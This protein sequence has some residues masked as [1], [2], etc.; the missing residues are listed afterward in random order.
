MATVI[1]KTNV[2]Q[3]SSVLIKDVGVS[4]PASGGSETFTNT[5]EISQLQLSRD[6]RDYLID[7]AYGVGSSTLI[8]NDGT[9][10]L[11]Q[12]DALNFLA[13]VQ[14]PDGDQDYGVIKTDAVG[15]VSTD[16]TFDGIATVTN[17]IAGNAIDAGSFKIV[18]L[19]AGVAATDAVNVSQLQAAVTEGKV[20]KEVVLISQQ[21]DS[22]NDALSQA[23]PFYLD[24]QP[25]IGD[26]FI[27]TDGSTTETF[28]FVAVE[29]LAFDV[30]IGGSTDLTLANL[31]Q[32]I[33]DDSTLWSAMLSST[34][35]S[36]NDGSG[37]STAG[38]VVVIYRTD[39]S[40][41]D[42][43]PD[44]IYGSLTTAPMGSTLTS[45]ANTI[46][47]RRLVRHCLLPTLLRNSSVSV[48]LRSL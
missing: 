5:D 10:D 19:Q 34:L 46:T 32:A 7:D 25:T 31:A 37:T 9:S 12:T 14:L 8:L 13:T 16:I 42:T 21:L 45:L 39:Q 4:I 23:I 11:A 18:N 41:A 35:E 15:E 24:G 22:V 44:R 33:T 3:G 17:L 38:K 20:W 40:A 1:V 43:Y 36:L 48:A 2:L 26:T 28:T 27:I 30:G 29:A 6:L 47:R